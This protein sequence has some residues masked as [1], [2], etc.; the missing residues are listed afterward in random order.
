LM[1]VNW[2]SMGIRL[3]KYQGLWWKNILHSIGWFDIYGI[4][5][6][7]KFNFSWCFME[8]S[9]Y[10]ILG[11]RYQSHECIVPLEQWTC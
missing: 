8:S 7:I 1:Y 11:W 4:K 9:Y 6:P 2:E 3:L 10:S 5:V